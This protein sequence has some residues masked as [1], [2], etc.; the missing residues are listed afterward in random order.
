MKFNNLV[1]PPVDIVMDEFEEHKDDDSSWYSPP[2]YSCLGGYKMCLKV[3]ANGEGKG[4][5][6]HVSVFIHLM[7]G[8]FDDDLKWPFNGKITIQLKRGLTSSLSTEIHV[9]I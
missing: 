6:T 9:L 1:V 5:G 7:R 3:L 2:F 4:K 8:E